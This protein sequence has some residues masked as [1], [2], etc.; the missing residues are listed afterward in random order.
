MVK[1]INVDKHGILSVKSS[2]NTDIS[3]LYKK[4]NLK[5]TKNFC[6]RHTWNVNNNYFSLYAKDSGRSN[7]INKYEL[8]P[9]LDKNLF[10]G[11]MLILKHSDND[12]NND[13]LLDVEIDEWKKCYEKL[14][15]GFIDLDDNDSDESDELD[16]IPDSQKTK[17]GYLKDGF[18]VEDDDVEDDDEFEEEEE[19]F[20]DLNED[21]DEDDEDDA[22]D[23]E[24]SEQEDENNK[25]NEEDEQDEEEDENED[26]E[27]EE[28]YEYADSDEYSELSEDSYI[29]SDED[30]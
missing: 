30:E 16:N 3:E 8:P 15:G 29:T 22:D 26:E 21:G 12:I 13:N 7:N 6:L 27:E 11:K 28:D 19:Y 9:P 2:R 1:I 20:S 23:D 24:E 5:N 14:F 25:S 10:Y 17:E 4:C 18:V